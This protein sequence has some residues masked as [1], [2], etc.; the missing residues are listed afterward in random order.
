VPGCLQLGPP[1]VRR[2]PTNARIVSRVP[3]P[4]RF[5]RFDCTI[6]ASIALTGLEK[7]RRTF[8]C[9]TGS[10]SRRKKLKEL[11]HASRFGSAGN[12]IEGNFHA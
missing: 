6:K 9:R 1:D 8:N 5:Y 4:G 10:C 3:C 7:A 12:V 2:R 11:H